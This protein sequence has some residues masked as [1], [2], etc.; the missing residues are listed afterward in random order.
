MKHQ[1]LT[2]HLAVCITNQGYEISTIYVFGDVLKHF[3]NS[4]RF[5]ITTP[6]KILSCNYD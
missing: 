1:T 2:V 5:I 4:Q 3:V 6:W